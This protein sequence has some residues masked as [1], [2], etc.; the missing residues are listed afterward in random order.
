MSKFLE[1]RK[2]FKVC[3][4]QNIRGQRWGAMGQEAKVEG[5]NQDDEEGP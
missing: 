4:R 3:V 5:K 2:I 1:I